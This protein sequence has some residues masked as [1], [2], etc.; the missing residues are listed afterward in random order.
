[1]ERKLGLI[2]AAD[3]LATHTILV[4]AVCVLVAI[5]RSNLDDAHVSLPM[6]VYKSTIYIF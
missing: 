6:I 5:L 4:L 2:Y 1:M 3:V